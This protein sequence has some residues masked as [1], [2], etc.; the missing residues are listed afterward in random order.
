MVFFHRSHNSVTAIGS[1]KHGLH[2]QVAGYFREIAELAVARRR[3][4]DRLND[5]A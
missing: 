4:K 2:F 3:S 5:V 1:T